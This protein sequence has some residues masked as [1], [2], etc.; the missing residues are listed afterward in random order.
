MV[1]IKKYFLAIAFLFMPFLTVGQED[2]IYVDVRGYG[3]SL[4][5]ARITAARAALSEYVGTFIDASY[6]VE[7]KIQIENDYV[8]ESSI[9]EENIFEYSQGV[10]RSIDV[11]S[12]VETDGFYEIEARV[13]ISKQE[14]ETFVSEK[15]RE[16]REV[17]TG[18]FAS[19]VT[20]RENRL[21][22]F[23]IFDEAV[24]S[25]LDDN[26]GVEVGIVGEIVEATLE[27]YPNKTD[28]GNIVLKIPI[29]MK[30]SDN[31][32][33]RA[34]NALENISEYSLYR[35]NLFWSN[36]FPSVRDYDLSPIVR[37]FIGD[38]SYIPPTSIE[39]NGLSEFKPLL[40]PAHRGFYSFKYKAD[41]EVRMFTFDGETAVSACSLVPEPYS[42]ESR[43][44]YVSKNY[45][46]ARVISL[47][48]ELIGNSG[49]LLSDTI[50]NIE[51]RDFENFALLNSINDNNACRVFIDTTSTVNLFIEV[52]DAILSETVDIRIQSI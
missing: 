45:Y 21:G 22:Q 10:V 39:M 1:F 2:V 51:S 16:I 28:Q 25:P 49:V 46:M 7:E 38:L 6:S 9:I 20:N 23:G 14:T 5:E 8:T 30:V 24:W 40:L 48:I 52:N 33:T 3:E 36:G 27:E 19:I 44:K 4:N 31:Y 43:Q 35:D 29:T 17:N 13:G 12:G 26:E 18:L 50:S 11:I 42:P 37:V 32:L 41:S 47:K 34:I 15:L